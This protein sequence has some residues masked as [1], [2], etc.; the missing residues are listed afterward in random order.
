M[1]AS[2]KKTSVIEVQL[3]EFEAQLRR[4]MLKEKLASME[5]QHENP[6]GVLP[7]IHVSLGQLAA[8]RPPVRPGTHASGD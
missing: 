8:S 7:T 2:K 4:Q 6:G 5:Q 1:I 3:K